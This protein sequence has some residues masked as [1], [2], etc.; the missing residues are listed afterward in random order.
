MI[1]NFD[2]LFDYLRSK[3]KKRLAAAWAVDDHTICAVA[4]AIKEGLVDGTLVGDENMMC[5][6]I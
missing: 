1:T 5:G 3:P 2:Q 4:M 6:A